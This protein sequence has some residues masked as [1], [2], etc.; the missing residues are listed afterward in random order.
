MSSEIKH[1]NSF[2]LPR[3]EQLV[4]RSNQFNLRTQRHSATHLDAI[5]KSD[6]FIDLTFTLKDKF[7]DN[8]LIAVVILEKRN[9]EMFI[10]TWLMSCRILRRGVENFVLN[11]I[12]DK[13]ERY[14]CELLIGEYIETKKNNMVKEL[15]PNLGFGN[16]EDRWVLKVQEFNNREHFIKELI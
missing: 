13:I 9:K 15:L 10:D 12:V 6:K 16:D 7:G 2:N 1:F 8:G 5:R 14:N 4:Q 11:A 3:V